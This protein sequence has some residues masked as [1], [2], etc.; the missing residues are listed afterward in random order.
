MLTPEVLTTYMVYGQ[1]NHHEVLS[2]FLHCFVRL[3]HR[4]PSN[5]ELIYFPIAMLIYH[6]IPLAMGLL[7][8][9]AVL[10]RHCLRVYQKKH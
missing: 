3:T 10:L 1:E 7:V 4:F 6:H 5:M 8:N 9:L 2:R